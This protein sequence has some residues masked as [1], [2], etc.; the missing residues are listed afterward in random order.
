MVLAQFD[1]ILIQLLLAAAV[2]SAVL[3]FVE[4]DTALPYEAIAILA[5]VMA[6]GL[7]GYIQQARA[8][9]AVEALR[10]M[11]QTRATVVR[12]HQRQQIPS[13]DLACGDIICLEE[14]DIVPADARL[15]DG[16]GLHVAEAAL[17][18]E[19]LP[20][21]KDPA[22]IAD[23]AAIGDQYNMLFSGTA[24]TSGRGRAV[25]TATGTR[26]QMGHI[27]GLMQPASDERTPLQQELDRLGRQLAIAVVAIALVM[28]VIILGT[29]DLHGFA[30]Y[31]DVILLGVA[32]AVAAIPEGLPAVVT[33]VL[34][35][36]VQRMASRNAVIRHL[37]AVETLG[38]A[39][40]IATDKTGTL[41]RN[42]MTVREIVTASG[43]VRFEGIGY[44]P[45]GKIEWHECADNEAGQRAELVQLLTAAAGAN[46][47]ELKQDEGG[48]WFITG[49]PTDAALIVA[50]RKAD[51]AAIAIPA[52]ER[53]REFPFSSQRKMMSSIARTDDHKEPV[54]FSKGAL[55]AILE[56][57]TWEQVGE[58]RCELT[59]QR[60]N[61]IRARN[62]Q[63][64]D[65]AL[66]TL[67][68][69]WRP[70]AGNPCEGTDNDVEKDLVFLGLVGMIDPP[71]VEAA[72]AVAR[73]KH[74]GIRVIMITGDHPRTAS[75]IAR[76]LG[77]S[78]DGEVIRGLDL[79]TMPETQIESAVADTSVYAR[80]DPEHKLHIVR[81][82]QRGGMTV[83][84]TG[85]GV[86]DAPA[87]QAADIGVAMGITGTDV[88]REAA[89]MVLMDDNFATII[90][91]VEEGRAIYANIRKFLRYLLS[92]NIGEVMTMFLGVALSGVIGLRGLEG[93][94][95]LPL[96]AIHILW[97]N[98]ITDGAPAIALGLDP[99]KRGIM[100]EPPRS[101]RQG[102][103]TRE[104]WRGIILVGFIMAAGTLLVL[105]AG[106]PGGLVE[107]TGN[108]AHGQTLAFTT[109]TLFQLFNALN[110]RSD[111]ESAFR[112]LFENRWLWAA[113]GFSLLLQIGVVHLPV[114]QAAF[115][116]VSLTAADWLICAAVASS[117]LWVREADKFFAR[118]IAAR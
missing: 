88:S 67:A 62:D 89:D 55:I 97:I 34:S 117:V 63:L 41:T 111:H 109:L 98:L 77:I 8:K 59:T 94:L 79:A 105:D 91:A 90:T 43:S 39:N 66:R 5:I 93:G 102:I 15:F 46:N 83:A 3:W 61:Q 40:V 106:M 10:Q 82:L 70:I 51:A 69:A 27:A 6:N 56:K 100:D 9:N 14:G 4:R 52:Q 21:T 35:L 103:V 101:R 30:A 53:L 19:S 80:V 50:A 47:A 99:A 38:A 84:M 42:E 28:I 81:A 85:D 68:I 110:A 57:C 78:A 71:R 22:V 75:V 17:T 60:R 20:V 116:T 96:L 2:V 26:T 37:P 29:T 115:G 73:A 113:I 23:D 104:M 48:V 49:D 86:N 65:Q 36:G 18:G 58:K 87:L 24:V 13:T 76:E 12:D 92:S 45:A 107:G 54:L 11:T 16:I 25:V 32:L 74:A 64:A 31:F 33:A 114:L 1:D 72:E 112:G 95:V 7:L 118:A 44:E 108:L